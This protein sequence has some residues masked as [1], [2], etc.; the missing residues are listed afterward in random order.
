MVLRCLET[1][2]MFMCSLEA[3]S[4]VRWVGVVS[5]KVERIAKVLPTLFALELLCCF[6]AA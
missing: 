5:L 2:L 3:M 6:T 4:E 1:V